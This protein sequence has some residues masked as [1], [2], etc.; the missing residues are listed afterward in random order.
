MEDDSRHRWV[1]TSNSFLWYEVVY[2]EA[3]GRVCKGDWLRQILTLTGFNGPLFLFFVKQD[4]QSLG[5]DPKGC[6]N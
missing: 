5:N 6:P 1:N 4:S 3:K 2:A